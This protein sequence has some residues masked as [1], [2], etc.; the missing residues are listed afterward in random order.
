MP[1]I[2]KW[3]RI[4]DEYLESLDAGITPW[5]TTD[6]Y[7][8]DSYYVVLSLYFLFPKSVLLQDWNKSK[9]YSRSIIDIHSKIVKEHCLPF[10]ELPQTKYTN[11]YSTK[12]CSANEI[13]N[14]IEYSS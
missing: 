11:G 5:C 8:T 14:L 2:V 9:F 4:T 3:S 1:T 12:I 7:V 6:S 13:Y 10:E